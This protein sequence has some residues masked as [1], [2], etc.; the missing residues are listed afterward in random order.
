M[1]QYL[2][3]INTLLLLLIVGQA[4]SSLANG[5]KKY[6]SFTYKNPIISKDIPAIRD[7]QI[8]PY[9]GA[10]FLIG[11]APP[12]WGSK[13]GDDPSPGVKMWHS[14][15]L[16]HWKFHKLLINSKDVPDGAWYREKFW[17]PEIHKKG[18]KYYLTFNCQDF[19]GKTIYNGMNVCVAVSNKIDDQYE[20]VTKDKPLWENANDASLFTDDDGRTYLFVSDIWGCEVDLESMKLIGEKKQ[21]IRREPGKWDAGIIEGPMVFKRDGTYYLLYSSNTRGYE[22]GYAMSKSPLGPYVKGKNNPF[23]GAQNKNNPNFSGDL[24]SPYLGCGHNTIFKGPDGRDWICCH[25]ELPYDVK[26]PAHQY[27][28]FFPNGTRE[29]KL[30]GPYRVEF[31][32]IDPFWI[33]TNGDLF[34]NQ[35]SYTRQTVNW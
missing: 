21:L 17:A 15:D 9:E 11:S 8:I 13:N 34:S 30:N 7:P 1:N 12:F 20:I 16:I 24:N 22:I 18:N 14:T 29:A 19:N 27:K 23:Y 2:K 5:K 6:K 25:F 35:P 4:L 3:G 26:N 10:Y 32:G 28:D 31:L 33:D